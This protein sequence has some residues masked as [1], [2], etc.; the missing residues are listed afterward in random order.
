MNKIFDFIIISSGLGSSMA[1]LQL[2][3]KGTSVLTLEQGKKYRLIDFPESNSRLSPRMG[4]SLLTNSGNQ[5]DISFPGKKG[6]DRT[7]LAD[8]IKKA[9][10]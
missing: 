6:N 10:Q 5:N 3:E 8:M 1:A 4:A 7:S 9:K 2:A